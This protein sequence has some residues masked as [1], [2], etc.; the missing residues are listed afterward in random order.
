MR[1]ILYAAY[2][3]N[4]KVPAG[5]TSTRYEQVH[6]TPPNLGNPTPLCFDTRVHVLDD[7]EARKKK[8]PVGSHSRSQEGNVLGIEDNN[9]LVLNDHGSTLRAREVTPIN[10][11]QL[12]NRGHIGSASYSSVGANTDPT[13]SRLAIATIG[14]NHLPPPPNTGI[15]IG[16]DAVDAQVPPDHRKL[17]V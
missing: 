4:R 13:M 8:G 16:G 7:K 1:A 15:P 11:Q 3:L 9:Y 14:D 5:K 12:A 17:V 6:G 2:I 10:E